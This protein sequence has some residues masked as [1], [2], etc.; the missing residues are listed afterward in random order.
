M[1]HQQIQQQ[2][3]V[4]RIVLGSG[5]EKGLAQVGQRRRMDRI[6]HQPVVL[7][8]HGNQGAPRLFQRHRD[9]SSPKAAQQF[10]HP[11]LNHFGTMIERTA[12]PLAA[13]GLLQR[14]EMLPIGP[15]DGYEGRETRLGRTTRCG[16]K[17]NP[18]SKENECGERAGL[19]SAKAL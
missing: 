12:L 1:A 16:H 4:G 9:R 3:R 8:Q 2:G 19:A 18:P 11:A 6:H 13:A 10:S 17:T 7:R 5:R 15:I 14:E